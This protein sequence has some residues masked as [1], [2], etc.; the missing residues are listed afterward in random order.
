[1]R[2]ENCTAGRKG[3]E[4]MKKIA[5]KNESNKEKTSVGLVLLIVCGFA[6]PVAAGIAIYK[7]VKK[8]KAH[9]A[10][11]SSENADEEGEETA[12]TEA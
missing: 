6:L 4:Q 12:E 5:L 10:Q 1:M 11:N 2:P 8:M 9:S 3:V 7:L